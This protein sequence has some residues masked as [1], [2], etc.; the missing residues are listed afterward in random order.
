MSRAV[1]TL[2]DHVALVAALRAA[3]GADALIETHISSVLLAG[4]RAYK[5]K[6]PVAFG[7]LD[8][9]TLV[10]RAHYCAEELRLNRRTAPQLYLNVLPVTGAIDAPQLGGGGEPIEFALQM[11][12]F[13]PAQVLDQ[14]AARG[15]LE[16]AHIDALARAIAA[17]HEAAARAT[18]GARLGAPAT[19]LHWVDENLA[20]LR[21][22]S[23]AAVDRARLDALAD[24]T[25][26]AFD[27]LRPLIAA[28]QGAGFVRECHGD[29]HLGNA[30]LID[31]VPVLFDALEF[32]DELR[33]ID[34]ISDVAFLFMDLLDHAQ[35]A[36][37]WRM[38]GGY[39]EATGDYDGVALLRF[40][41]V[42]RALVRAKVAL[43]RV[44]QPAAPPIARVRAQ[45]NFAHYLALAERL[46]RPPPRPWLVVMT[47]L[48]GSGKSTVAQQLAARLGA[49][50]VRSD[51][52]R[53]RLAGL[54]AAQRG[55][56]ALYAPQMT[57]RTYAR[58]QQLAA[59]LLDAGVS[60]VVD[61][62]SLRAAE[63]RDLAQVAS[64]HG[65]RPVVV[66]CTAP[67]AVLQARVAARM[68]AGADPSDA[69]LEVLVR[70]RQWRDARAAD[71]PP[72]RVLDTDCSSA[73]LADR[74]ARLADELT[75]G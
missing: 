11:R 47:G 18:A 62:A 75:A 4:D 13:D 38:L 19:V 56:A 23:H 1:E 20:V 2:A 57:E 53:K 48:S 14:V 37:G 6:K 28:R 67:D 32:N 54:A 3:L 68:Q 60:V 45:A 61:A 49:L 65:A 31:G 66:E 29:L 72:W 30:V 58:L 7:F 71:E 16:P 41:A 46:E 39:L 24:F 33:W 15:A 59:G 21:A 64:V 22:G 63:R 9:S 69:T 35:P 74:C 52:E 73:A 27:R 26:H 50:R 12:R 42:Y 70:Q 40:Y 8:F 5:V 17:L 34:V 25:K 44:Q 36:L 55:A 43:L 51:V 10:L